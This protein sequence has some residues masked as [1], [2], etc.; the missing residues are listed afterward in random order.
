MFLGI[1]QK[2][3]YSSPKVHAVSELCVHLFTLKSEQ[4][5]F[6]NLFQ[7]TPLNKFG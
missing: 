3:D 5:N 4:V 2:Y 7:G 6:V 1:V